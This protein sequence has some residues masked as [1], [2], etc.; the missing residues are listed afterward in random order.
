MK[1]VARVAAIL[2]VVGLIALPI[3]EGAAPAHTDSELEGRFTTTVRPFIA[4]YCVGCHS[5]A[6]PAG[7]LNLGSY[8]TM[9]SVVHDFSRWTRVMQRLAGN[10]MPPA[11]MPQPPESAR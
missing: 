7:Q 9:S 10:E 6:T 1:F 5:G 4:S 11:T 8:S 3:G 2:F